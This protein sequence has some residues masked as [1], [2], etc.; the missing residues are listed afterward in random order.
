MDNKT[1]DVQAAERAHVMY[2]WDVAITGMGIVRAAGAA[3]YVKYLSECGHSRPDEY[4]SEHGHAV[5]TWRG[6]GAD[7][8]LVE[9]QL[10]AEEFGRFMAGLDPETGASRWAQRVEPEHVAAIDFLVNG[11]KEWSILAVLD[12]GVQAALLL[13]QVNAE[14]AVLQYLWE[15]GT[16][17]VKQA[18]QV[19]RV[20]VERIEIASVQHFSSRAGDPHF[21]RHMEISARVWAAGK[22]RALDSLGAR[23]LNVAVQAIFH[24]EQ[25]RALRPEFARLGYEVD[26]V[27][28]IALL[29]P[30]VEAMSRRAAQ[31][32]RN[33]AV[34]EAA[35]RVE[36]P[37]QEPTARILRKWGVLAWEKQRPYKGEPGALDA[38]LAV[39][40]ARIGELMVEHGITE[41]VPGSVVDRR[42]SVAEFDRDALA[43]QLVETQGLRRSAWSRADLEAAAIM[44]VEGRVRGDRAAVDEL[45]GDVVARALGE[46]RLLPSVADGRP[47][48]AVKW[49]TSPAVAEREN[50]LRAGLAV[51]ADNGR[52]S[53]VEGAAGVGKTTSLAAYLEEASVAGRRVAVVA[54][55]GAAAL[56]AAGAGVEAS[57]VDSLLGRYGWDKNTAGSW[58][59]AESHKRPREPLPPGS[60]LV[61]DEAGMVSQDAARALVT[62]AAVCGWQVR[63]QGDSFQFS[64]VGVGGVMEIAKGAAQ[65]DR[66]AL[67]EDASDVHRFRTADGGRDEAFAAHSIAIRSGTDPEA[68][69][70]RVMDR[71]TV[72]AS[73]A[74]RQTAIAQVWA[75]RAHAGTGLVIAGTN[76]DVQQLN[77]LIAD[78]LR[79]VGIVTGDTVATAPRGEWASETISE[80]DIVATRV[81]GVDEAGHRYANR[82]RWRVDALDDVGAYLISLDGRREL[83]LSV[84]AAREQLQL[85]YAVTGYGAQGVT[86]NEAV[87]LVAEGMDRPSFYVG[88]TRGRYTNQAAI[89]ATD[90]DA[91]LARAQVEAILSQPGA[92]TGWRAADLAAAADRQRMGDLVDMPS[93]HVPSIG[94]GQVAEAAEAAEQIA[95]DADWPSEVRDPHLFDRALAYLDR[96]QRQRAVD[97]GQQEASLEQLRGTLAKAIDANRQAASRVASA[98]RGVGQAEKA[99]KAAQEAVMAAEDRLRHANPFNRGSRERDLTAARDTLWAA[100]HAETGQRIRHAELT[101]IAQRQQEATRR[102]SR[103]VE[104]AET[105]LGWLRGERHQLTLD[106]MPLPGVEYQQS[107]SRAD[108]EALRDI[109]LAEPQPRD[110]ADP[111]RAII[112]LVN[113]DRHIADLATPSQWHTLADAA[114]PDDLVWGGDYDRPWL[115]GLRQPLV[116]WLGDQASRLASDPQWHESA[117]PLTSRW[118]TIEQASETRRAQL[119]PSRPPA[120]TRIDPH[121]EPPRLGRPGPDLTPGW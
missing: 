92:D 38:E 93:R 108:L 31:V 20:P 8:K 119:K 12:P 102:L 100:R 48:T 81:N 105:Q 25:L 28:Q 23:N 107:Y 98:T 15:N 62:L 121:G 117:D 66:V 116:G 4:F 10:T 6:I 55:T 59:W 3:G 57:T 109:W 112:D 40:A 19:V 88:S 115:R 89:L 34:I 106:L 78:R 60:R 33:L 67:L 43:A 53:V 65:P 17:Q 73:E 96:L 37:G 32:E 103:E 91:N 29:R 114:S 86:V 44:A 39:W 26:E 64:A 97:A 99:T 79:T 41:P 22:W 14:R 68:T 95:R 110:T 13:G 101:Q 54:P 24:R 61:I 9:R 74:E 77:G 70:A 63:V 35:W 7:G 71:A 18:G 46:S 30:V 5:V 50:E 90:G 11:P 72:Y 80:G 36:H 69:A 47:S 2:H 56:V 120:D 113:D 104:L 21:H 1:L 42:V 45:A 87:L 51:L 83:R 76:A 85:A 49:W 111:V 75:E 94:G 52:L 58:V 82:E 27:G 118:T 16:V 84:G